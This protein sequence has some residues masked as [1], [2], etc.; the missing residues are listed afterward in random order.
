MRGLKPEIL[1]IEPPPF[2]FRQ[3]PIV[4]VGPDHDHDE[5]REQAERCRQQPKI[6]DGMPHAP[7]VAMPGGN[8]QTAT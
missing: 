6:K 5:E 8:R 1:V 4:N 7:E 2:F 3:A